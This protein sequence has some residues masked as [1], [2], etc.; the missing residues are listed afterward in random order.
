MPMQY[1]PNSV[2]WSSGVD[3]RSDASELAVSSRFLLGDGIAIVK[4]IT[5]DKPFIRL[6]GG[7]LD[8]SRSD[9]SSSS[10]ARGSG[11]G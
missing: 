2:S 10:Y 3:A 8:P 6:S 1:S 7:T 5:T 4:A 11:G 9:I